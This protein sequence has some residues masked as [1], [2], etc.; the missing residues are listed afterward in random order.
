MCS[1]NSAEIDDE[2]MLNESHNAKQCTD[3]PPK[4]DLM[5]KMLELISNHR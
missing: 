2:K 1:K 5:F 4:S 3:D